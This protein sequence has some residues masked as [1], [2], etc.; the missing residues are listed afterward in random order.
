MV[1]RVRFFCQATVLLVVVCITTFCGCDI[2]TDN[3]FI[4]AETSC[5]E[6]RSPTGVWWVVP[7]Y[8]LED[9][10]RKMGAQGNLIYLLVVCPELSPIMRRTA[11]AYGGAINNY[12]SEWGTSTGKVSIA[13]SWNKRSDKVAIGKQEFERDRGNI[14]VVIRKPSGEL[15]CTQLASPASS[16]DRKSL[17][18]FIKEK[19]PGEPVIQSAELP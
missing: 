19:L 5:G 6:L 18:K 8:A 15:S 11:V 2:G 14:L 13:A 1:N 4:T 10:G 3:Q 17:L 7:G 16:L 9:K 12:V